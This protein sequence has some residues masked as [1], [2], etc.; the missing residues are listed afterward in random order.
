MEGMAESV[1]LIS[2]QTGEKLK[3]LLGAELS[4]SD[5]VELKSNLGLI[6]KIE[7]DRAK[8]MKELSTRYVVGNTTI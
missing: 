7:I 5:S 1:F 2:F 6:R 3:G 8:L 4:G